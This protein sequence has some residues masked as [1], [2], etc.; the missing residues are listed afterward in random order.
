MSRLDARATP[1]VHT[2]PGWWIMSDADILTWQA[3]QL[4]AVAGELDSEDFQGEWRGPA[5]LQCQ[6]RL[7][8]L[9]DDLYRAARVV[10]GASDSYAGG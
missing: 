5:H 6:L 8:E 10:E 4:R 2:L 7:R 3:R 1:L 9:R